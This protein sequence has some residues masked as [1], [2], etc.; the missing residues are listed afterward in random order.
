MRIKKNNKIVT[1]WNKYWNNMLAVF[2][3]LVVFS[4]QITHIFFEGA[5]MGEIVWFCDSMSYLLAFALWM[6]NRFLITVVFLASVPA[7][8]L[9]I[10]DFFLNIAGVGLGRTD[11]LFIDSN[12]W[13]TPY[14]ST[15][16]HG[17]LIPSALYGVW[18]LGF[19]KKAIFGV[20]AI[21][22]I[23][24]PITYFF[25]D[26]TINRNCVF[27]PCD[28]NFLEDRAEIITNSFYMTP[29]YLLKEIGLW[30]FYASIFYLLVIFF[31]SQVK[32]IKTSKEL[33]TPN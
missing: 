2:I 5:D 6:K 1:I 21:I 15:I 9:W 27:Y 18:K 14:I 10:V 8:F 26:P 23:L 25:T 12:V 32:K 24:L 19:V 29:A 31:M 3:F 17:I 22:I 4:N 20:Y 33:K 16:M 7:Q 13:W 11:W 30:I 28:L